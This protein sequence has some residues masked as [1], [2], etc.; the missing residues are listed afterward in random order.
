MSATIVV[1]DHLYFTTPDV[2]GQFTIAN[3]PPGEYAGWLARRV[4]EQTSRVTVEGHTAADVPAR[5]KV[6]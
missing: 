3:V 1:L 5:R 2:D 6:R 4:G